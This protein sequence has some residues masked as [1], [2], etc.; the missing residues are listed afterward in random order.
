VA[1][2]FFAVSASLM[3][4]LLVRTD[5]IRALG[6]GVFLPSVLG[7]TAAVCGVAALMIIWYLLTGWNEQKRRA[8]VLQ[9]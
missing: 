1:L 6:D 3:R 9:I 4:Q 8:G 7:W 5:L 2:F